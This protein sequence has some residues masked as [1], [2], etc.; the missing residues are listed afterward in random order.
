MSSDPAAF[1]ASDPGG[2]GGRGE[3]KREGQPKLVD[4][5]ARDCVTGGEVMVEGNLVGA[6]EGADATMV[7]AA[8]E[9]VAAVAGVKMEERAVAAGDVNMTDVAPEGG[10]GMVS[11]SL[12][13]TESTGMVGAEGCG[14]EPSENM[15]PLNGGAER[16]RM[17]GMEASGLR[18]E[19]EKNPVQIEPV[20]AETLEVSPQYAEA[21][22]HTAHSS[23]QFDALPVDYTFFPNLYGIIE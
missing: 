21:S 23:G 8:T 10:V 2:D 9:E 15:Q 14:D 3:M 19:A 7:E 6:A 13:A 22:E 16:E 5:A 4:A 20:A 17:L 1:A 11:D 18:G 12:Y